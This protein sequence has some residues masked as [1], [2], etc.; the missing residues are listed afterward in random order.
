MKRIIVHKPITISCN[1][2][3]RSI[4]ILSLFVLFTHSLLLAQLPLPRITAISNSVSGDSIN[5]FVRILSG[6]DPVTINSQTWYITSRRPGTTTYPIA[7]SYIKSKLEGYGLETHEQYFS[8]TYSGYNV[9][10]VQPGRDPDQVYIICAHYDAVTNYAADDNATG[11]AAVLEAARLLS[12]YTTEYTVIY[13][14]WDR[15]E[16]GLV[17]SKYFAQWA[18]SNGM[19]IRRVINLDMLGWDSN[20]DG[21]AEIHTQ[22]YASSVQLANDMV[23]INSTYQVGLNPVIK[24]PGVTNSDHS[25]F[26]NKGFSAILLIEGYKSGDF[27][28][29]YHTTSDRYST[30]NLNYLYKMSKMSITT[31]ANYVIDSYVTLAG[32]VYHDGDRLEDGMVDGTGTNAGGSLYVNLL[33]ADG[34]VSASAPVS[35]DGSYTLE[36]LA[37][38]SHSLQLTIHQGAVGNSAP[39]TLLPPGWEYIGEHFAGGPPH[40]GLADGMISFDIDID[41]LSAEINFGI[42]DAGAAVL[43]T[44][45]YCGQ[46]ICNGE[47]ITYPP[48][49]EGVTVTLQGG[50]QTYTAVTDENGEYRFDDLP[51]GTYTVVSSYNA[52]TGG[53]VNALDAG[54]VNAWGVGPQSAIEFFRFK[55]GNVVFD[56]RINSGDAGRINLFSLNDGNPAWEAPV[57]MWSFWKPG[58]II[59]QNYTTEGIY[60]EIMVGT[61]DVTQHFFGLVTGDFNLS[62]PAHLIPAD[63][64]NLSGEFRTAH[65]PSALPRD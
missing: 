51:A 65:S 7:R 44:Y 35:A 42:D 62:M 6:E 26:W 23:T 30:L 53:A 58:E 34:I 14:L 33:G 48:P 37:G 12:C 61:T 47:F 15:E 31:L 4:G 63:P 27:T 25:S 41:D 46:V 52:E 18:K 36:A 39:S 19:D 60:P 17:G 49:L 10:A 56:N 22:N 43:G 2:A 21:L 8:A 59:S 16:N 5:S 55:A 20:N 29:Y 64:C 50:G 1:G 11:V 13:A 24:Y 3:F 45:R 54:M 9:Y 32:T 38:A 28:P 57:E 40:D